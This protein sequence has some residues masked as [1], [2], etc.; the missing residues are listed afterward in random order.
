MKFKQ[1]WVKNSKT[2][3]TKDIIVKC[4]IPNSV[5]ELLLGGGAIVGGV[6]LLTTGA[7]KNGSKAFEKAELEALNNAELLKF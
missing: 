5:F 7:F 2:G 1:G 6:I 4:K 3:A